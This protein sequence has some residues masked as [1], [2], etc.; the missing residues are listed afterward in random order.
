MICKRKMIIRG[1]HLKSSFK[2][3]AVFCN[4]PLK[5]QEY[6]FNNIL[7]MLSFNKYNLTMQVETLENVLTTRWNSTIEKK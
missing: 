6:C 7:F 4:I 1:K 5:S 3:R 2:V